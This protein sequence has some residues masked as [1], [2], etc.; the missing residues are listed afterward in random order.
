MIH[1]L[2]RLELRDR[3]HH[4]KRVA[5]QEHDV[6]GM[7][8]H[9]FGNVVRDV[10]NG[11]GG[12]RIL[13][14]ALRIQIHCARLGIHVHIFQHG[15]EHFRRR[16]DL[17]FTLARQPDHFR[18]AAALEVEDPVVG[19]PV[20]VVADQPALGIGGERGLSRTGQAK[21]QRAIAPPAHIGG[22]VLVQLRRR[23]IPVDTLLSRYA[24]GLCGWPRLAAIL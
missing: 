23:Q 11:I 15:A 10:V 7:G 12:A 3:R 9:A 2:L 22:A 14:D 1:R 13:R 20:L 8:G 18:V 4:A 16:V 19:P 17:R 21:E 5:R 24:H 6:R